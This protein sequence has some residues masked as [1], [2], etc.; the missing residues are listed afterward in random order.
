MCSL[1]CRPHPDCASESQPHKTVG[2]GGELRRAPPAT[3]AYRLSHLGAPAPAAGRRSRHVPQEGIATGADLGS[4]DAATTATSFV[5]QGIGHLHAP[6]AQYRCG[7]PGYRVCCRS[8]VLA[9]K[10]SMPPALVGF[11]SCPGLMRSSGL[12]ALQQQRD[13]F[14]VHVQGYVGSGQEGVVVDAEDCVGASGHLMSIG[15]VG[16]TQHG[17]GSSVLVTGQ[18]PPR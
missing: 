14:H 1:C 15:L 11:A 13:C 4:R 16:A 8:L 9:T 3:P 12:T 6:R 7:A 5:P 18:C 10:E 17:T 2:H